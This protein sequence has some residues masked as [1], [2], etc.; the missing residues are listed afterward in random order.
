M[1]YKLKHDIQHYIDALSDQDIKEAFE[2]YGFDVGEAS[3]NGSDDPSTGFQLSEPTPKADEI[4]FKGQ[5]YVKAKGC[6]RI[7]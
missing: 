6:V 2:A 1:G 4:V 7:G 3:A 5:T